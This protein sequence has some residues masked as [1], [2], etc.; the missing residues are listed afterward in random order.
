VPNRVVATEVVV[1]NRVIKAPLS[2]NEHVERV[3]SRCR[4]NAPPPSPM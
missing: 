2:A 4:F 1:D 3:P